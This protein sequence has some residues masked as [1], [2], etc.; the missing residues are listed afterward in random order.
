MTLDE[1]LHITVK[2]TELAAARGASIAVAVV[3][4][5]GHLVTLHRMDG[6]PFIAAEIAW[7]KA[8]PPPGARHPRIRQSRP[9]SYP[10]SP[11]RL[12]WPA[13]PGICRK[14]VVFPSAGAAP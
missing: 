8:W 10:S 9:P 7:G 2:S 5:G 11:Q 1:A 3:D 6:V 13:A 12:P 4:A 14:P